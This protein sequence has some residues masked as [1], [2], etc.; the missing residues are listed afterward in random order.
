[1]SCTS[2][3]QCSSLG[4][5]ECQVSA[6]D[7]SSRPAARGRCSRWWPAPSRRVALRLRRH[8]SVSRSLS[9]STAC[10][11]VPKIWRP[12][13]TL[14]PRHHRKQS[15]RSISTPCR[16][17]S[18]APTGRYGR[19]APASAR[20]G[21]ST[22]TASILWACA[23]TSCR[24]AR[25]ANSSIRPTASTTRMRRS[26]TRC[27]P[28]LGF[29]VFASWTGAARRPTGPSKAQAIFARPARTPS[30]APRRV[31]SLSTPPCRSRKS[32]HASWSSGWKSR[33][34]MH[35]RSPSTRSSMGPAS[36][37]PIAS[38]R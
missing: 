6:E 36:P 1:M 35:S 21:C 4:Y 27:P 15:A 28:I 20:Y 34:L 12:S 5:R 23:S 10:A 16:R 7:K 22:S 33:M 24:T 11:C 26:P 18:S 30:T 3:Q 29:P 2:R 31:A 17:S 9:A 25:R 13:R 8:A 19:P 37:V 38:R 14:R 32:F